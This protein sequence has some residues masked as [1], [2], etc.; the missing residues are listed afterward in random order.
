[1]CRYFHSWDLRREIHEG[2][3]MG[4]EEQPNS[5]QS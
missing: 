4:F 5:K 2:P 1:L 3:N